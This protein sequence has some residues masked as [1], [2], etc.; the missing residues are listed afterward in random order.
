MFSY[1]NLKTTKEN[2]LE[3]HSRFWRRNFNQLNTSIFDQKQRFKYL[4]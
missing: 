1:P 2:G 3:H 4:E